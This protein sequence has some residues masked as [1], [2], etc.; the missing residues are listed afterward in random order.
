[1]HREISVSLT[2]K[3]LEEAADAVRELQKRLN[4]DRMD[5][6]I[7]DI[8]TL[9]MADAGHTYGN[10]VKVTTEA[11]ENGRDVVA[12]GR[13]VMF[14]EF[15]A[16]T[17]TDVG[18]PYAENAPAPIEPGSYS[19]EHAGMFEEL[20]YWAFGG[21]FYKFVAPRRALYKAVR[22]VSPKIVGIVKRKFRR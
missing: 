16:G 6:A 7:F 8:A 22:L 14:L 13:A 18:H 5:N 12:T 17:E 2:S 19:R 15:G 21:R 9:I 1:M 4:G 20:G 11:A 10:S 3:G